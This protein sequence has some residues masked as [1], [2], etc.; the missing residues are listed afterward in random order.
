MVDK[1]NRFAVLKALFAVIVWGTSFVATK[2]SLSFVGP[3]TVVWL[4][5]QWG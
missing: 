4:R 1:E 5:L 3:T 2:V